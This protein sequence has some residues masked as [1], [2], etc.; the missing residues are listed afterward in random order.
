M[1]LFCEGVLPAENSYLK[2]AR[3][4]TVTDE[5]ILATARSLF[6][7]KGINASTR[8]IA[9]Q[10]GISE[11][12]IFQRFE[13]KENLFFSAMV[14]P[15]AKLKVI[16]SCQAGE[17]TVCENLKSVS[18]QIV[19]Y[20]RE[21]MPIFL[22]LIN[23]PAFDMQVFLQRHTLPRVQISTRL[24]EYLN[25]EAVLGR[26]KGD[27]SLATAALLLSHLHHIA[28]SQNMGAH[29]PNETESAVSDAIHVLWH[30]IVRL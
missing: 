23:H 8:A 29:P 14:L 11:T 1:A 30:G 4:K 20:F 26:I 3:T 12:V 19:D 28:L 7:E 13:T 18:L 5:D 22:S 9:K 2:M 6:L 15:E 17:R 10:A 16:F 24:V 25:A 27:S 21:V